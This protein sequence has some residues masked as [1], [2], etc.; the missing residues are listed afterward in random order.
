MNCELVT[1]QTFHACL[2]LNTCRNFSK[3]NTQDRLHQSSYDT[4]MEIHVLSTLAYENKKEKKGNPLNH[5]PDKQTYIA[6]DMPLYKTTLNSETQYA[7]QHYT[8]KNDLHVPRAGFEPTTF[9]VL[10]TL[11]LYC[12]C[13]SS[14]P[15]IQGKATNLI[16]R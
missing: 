6:R 12:A 16:N 1:A 10:D 5:D 7:I 4:Y 15:G 8:E 11:H 13:V 3:C 2:W 9:C 14:N